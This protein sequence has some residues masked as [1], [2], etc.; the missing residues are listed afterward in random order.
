MAHDLLLFL[1]GVAA[2]V[3]GYLVGLA[4][5]VSYPV[6]M[7]LGV[8]PVVANASNTVALVPGG[9]GAVLSSWRCL[10]QVRTYPMLALLTS[11]TLGGVVGAVLL[12]AAPATAFQTLVPWLVLLATL[13]IAA[14][15]RIERHSGH[16]RLST[17][18]FLV[19][20]GVVAVYGG[21][22]GAGS[23]IMFLALCSLGTPLTTHESVLLKTPLMTVAN[24]VA[25]IL[26]ILAGAVDWAA[27]LA[28]GLGPFVGGLL[29]PQIQRLIPERVMRVVVVV[30]GL[31]LTAWLLLQA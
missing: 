11:A 21:Y 30:G 13:L 9:V 3:L 26:F 28:V 5:L 15:P 29:G 6:M 8:P 17:P 16:V 2:G 18:V 14:G 7:A 22:F 10:K 23:G 4:S 31:V 20:L 27:A 19:L 24:V 12:L 25:S 1:A